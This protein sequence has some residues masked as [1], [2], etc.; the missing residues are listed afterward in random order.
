MFFSAIQDGAAVDTAFAVKSYL[1]W[2]E[3]K[4][5]WRWRHLSVSVTTPFALV[6]HA[7]RQI[8]SPQSRSAVADPQTALIGTNKSIFMHFS[9]GDS[10][11]SFKF[12]RET[13]T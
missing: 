12:N 10:G 13:A 5:G 11:A 2:S 8:D 3:L 9:K 7:A 4:S 1:S 6:F